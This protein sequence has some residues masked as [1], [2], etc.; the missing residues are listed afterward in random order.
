M[1]FIGIT[2]GVGAGKSAALAYL[3][4]Q[5]KIRAMM[6]DRIAEELMEPGGSCYDALRKLF[7][8]DAVWKEDGH[9]NR[10]A[11]AEVLFASE[12]KRT[13]VNGLVHP[14]V[15]QYVLEQKRLE[16]ERGSLD[17]L[18]LEAALLI[19]EHYDEIC[20]EL[21]YIY[22]SRE[23]RKKR[24]MENRGYS[25][26]KVEQIFASQLGEEEYRSACAAVIDNDGTPEEMVA[27]I[28][29]LLKDKGEGTD[30]KYDGSE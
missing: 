27:Q 29:E 23:V 13:A 6:A 17:F 20:D 16:E 18:I 28:R 5:E 3:A 1:K 21:W 7:A 24:L 25:S 4:G 11:M 26:E 22:T 8:E 19:E 2:G 9:I 15:R 10:P 14:A 30:G 12:E